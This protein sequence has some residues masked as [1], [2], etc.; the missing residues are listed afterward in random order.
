[1]SLNRVILSGTIGQYGPKIE[2]TETGKA[3]TSFT[4][5]CE[6]PRRGQS[7]PFKTF[8][9]V[10]IVGAQA[11]ACAETLEAGDVVVLEGKLAWKAGK[12]KDAG[13]LHVVAFSVESMTPH[14]MINSDKL[15]A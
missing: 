13:R 7:A 4:L 1:M 3:Q 15:E 11:E 8:I 14:E 9:P 2:W 6:E 12:S 5:V 10:L